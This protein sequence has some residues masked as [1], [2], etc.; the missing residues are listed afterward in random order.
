MEYIICTMFVFII[1]REWMNWK[2]RHELT[3]KLMAKN[4][5]EY[6]AF[7]KQEI[8][9]EKQEIKAATIPL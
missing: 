8:K 1:V 3:K 5:V 2:E 7:E 9:K 4:F 6:A